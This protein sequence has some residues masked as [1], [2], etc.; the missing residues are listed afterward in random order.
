M[1]TDPRGVWTQ[2]KR[3]ATFSRPAA[4]LFDKSRALAEEI[5]AA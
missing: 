3:V 1:E 4:V 2:V 5:V